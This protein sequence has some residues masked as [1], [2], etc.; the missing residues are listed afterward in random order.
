MYRKK[1]KIVSTYENLGNY[2]DGFDVYNSLFLQRIANPTLAREKYIITVYE[3]R[4]DLIAKDYYGS[5]SYMG[6]LLAQIKLTVDQLER[7]VILELL[8]KTTIE[9][10]I[11]SL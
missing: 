2:I 10:I 11:N 6:I 4:P 8:P 1:S 3:Y 5:T 9:S 7:G